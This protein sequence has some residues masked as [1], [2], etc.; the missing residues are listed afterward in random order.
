MPCETFLVSLL[1]L[2]TSTMST[3]VED[4][5]A[6]IIL[7]GDSLSQLGFEGWAST[8]A[9]VYQRRADVINRG[10]SGYNTKNYLQFVPLPPCNN[11]CLVTLFFGANDASLLEENPRQHVPIEDYSRNLK[12]LVQRVQE[13]YSSPRILLINPPPLDHEQRLLFQKQRYGNLATGRLERTTEN[14]GRYADAC[15]AVARD[16]NI[17]CL[18]L[19]HNMLHVPDYSRF[20]CDGLH[21]SAVGHDFVADQI[22]QAMQKHFPE[23]IVT[24]CPQTGQWNN[25]AS[26]C[27]ALPSLGPYHDLID[28]QN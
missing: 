15:L 8:I 13:K 20:L 10:C 25:S 21:F 16:L 19:F 24:P 14:T 27:P 2:K 3:T 17:P 28:D 26:K 6:Q 9:N 12:S 11:V 1:L 7:L 18:D 23:L 4:S 5:T 22:L